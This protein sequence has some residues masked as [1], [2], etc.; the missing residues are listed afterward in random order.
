[1][2]KK[3]SCMYFVD[4]EKA[5]DRVQKKVLEWAMRKKGIAE[6]LVRSV[7]SLYEGAMTR[8]RLDSELSE[9]FEAKVGMHQ[10]SVLS[11][12]LFEVEV[13]VVTE[14]ARDGVLNELL[15]VDLVMKSETIKGLSINFIE[16]KG[17][18]VQ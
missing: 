14:F 11:F 18:V 16:L 6:V 17:S 9:E 5:F 3:K 4:L 7:M 12:F 10:G 8:D 1:M 15:Y 2:L 13:D